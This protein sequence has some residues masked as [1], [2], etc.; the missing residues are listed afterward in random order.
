M[1]CGSP[2]L[3]RRALRGL[4]RWRLRVRLTS[5]RAESTEWLLHEGQRPTAHLRSRGEHL[6]APHP[7][8][9]SSGSPPLARRA[10]TGPMPASTAVRLTSARAES[11]S[12]PRTTRPRSAAHLRSR[13][14]HVTAPRRGRPP[15]GSPP[16]ARR[17]PQ[18][19]GA[20]RSGLRLTSARAESTVR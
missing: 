14:E 17:A 16:L 9:N 18:A 2:P 1:A 19:G 10:R 6:L 13:G 20:V 3:A 7:G 4:P 11:T 5:A 12:V 15:V 8:R